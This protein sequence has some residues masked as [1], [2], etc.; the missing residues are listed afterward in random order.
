MFCFPVPLLVS[1]L[2]VFS[3]IKRALSRSVIAGIMQNVI[4]LYEILCVILE[5]GKVILPS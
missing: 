5:C 1:V 4:V 3:E 2:V